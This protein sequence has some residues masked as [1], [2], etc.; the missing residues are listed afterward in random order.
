MTSRRFVLFIVA[1]FPL[2]VSERLAAQAPEERD[3]PRFVVRISRPFL[4]Q[5]TEVDFAREDPVNKCILGARVLGNVHLEGKFKLKLQTSEKV[6]GFHLVVQGKV[7]GRSA[8]TRRGIVGHTHGKGTFD[9]IRPVAFDGKAFVGEPIQVD[10]DYRVRL[11]GLTLQRPRLFGGLVRKIA[12]RK[13]SS[14]L[15]EGERIATRDLERSITASVQTESDE[16]L[17]A[18]NRATEV[19]FNIVK[20]AKTRPRFAGVEP[21]IQ[22]AAS[23]EHLLLGIADKPQRLAELPELS[24]EHRAPVEVWVRRPEEK[25]VELLPTLRKYWTALKPIL[26]VRLS[27]TVPRFA[28]VLD[29][30]QL[31][32]LTDWQVVRFYFD[33]DKN[34]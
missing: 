28:E 33:A 17:T 4:A 5:L 12:Y 19:A 30:V 22:L 8:A 31:T 27:R 15:P 18:L 34:R 29:N 9:A 3:R 25:E 23:D 24:T 2:V 26:K 14:N 16:M 20:Y 13:A 1:M 10:V 7:V 32:E 11:E 21:E 6:E